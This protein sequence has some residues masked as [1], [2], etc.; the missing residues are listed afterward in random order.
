MYFALDV[1]MVMNYLIMINAKNVLFKIV[2]Y[3]IKE[4]VK[5]VL[6]DLYQMKKEN[7]R[8]KK[9]FKNVMTQIV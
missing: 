2:R 4:N 8:Y 6:Q 5:V 9:N 3:A 7:V 1:N